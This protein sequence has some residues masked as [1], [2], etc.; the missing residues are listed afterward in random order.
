M[1]LF[2][3]LHGSSGDQSLYFRGNSGYHKLRQL[4]QAREE[5]EGGHS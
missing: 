2:V 3:I 5:E 4:R 1:F